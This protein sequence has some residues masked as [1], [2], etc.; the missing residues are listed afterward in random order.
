MIVSFGCT[1]L[2][3]CGAP[4][5]STKYVNFYVEY[6][7]ARTSYGHTST[8]STAL[9]CVQVCMA[10]KLR[11][12]SFLEL[13]SKVQLVTGGVTNNCAHD[14]MCLC[15]CLYI[16]VYICMRVYIYAVKQH[17]I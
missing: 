13:Q 11:V 5:Y 17:T 8:Y 7:K 10:A 1:Q 3:N 12:L 6:S 14:S 9:L 16:H 4:A 2:K 15:M